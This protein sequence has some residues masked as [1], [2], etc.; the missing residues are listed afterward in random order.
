MSNDDPLG[1]LNEPVTGHYAPAA[2]GERRSERKTNYIFICAAIGAGV[3]GLLFVGAMML[4][5]NPRAN[6]Q[7][8]PKANSLVGSTWIND[9]GGYEQYFADGTFTI[10]QL[11]GHETWRIEGDKLIVSTAWTEYYPDGYVTYAMVWQ[12]ANHLAL[13][14]MRYKKDAHPWGTMSPKTGSELTPKDMANHSP[15]VASVK[16]LVRICSET[17]HGNQYY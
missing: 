17:Q 5:S 13:V 1:F 14:D 9:A 15:T 4:Q 3:L 12:D 6:S 16:R 11:E 7:T 8:N 10:A 2:P